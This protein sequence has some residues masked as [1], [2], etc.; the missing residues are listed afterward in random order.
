VFAGDF[1][2]LFIFALHFFFG[3]SPEAELLGFLTG[4]VVS[5]FPVA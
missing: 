3:K 5:L 1:Y 2:R 4:Y